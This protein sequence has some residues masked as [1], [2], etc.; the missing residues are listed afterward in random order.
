M[1]IGI[2]SAPEIFQHRM[3]ELIEGMP[4]VEV[5][6]DDFVVVGYRQT[7]EQA[8]RD[9]DKNLMKFLQQCQDCRLKFDIKNLTLKQTKVSFIGDVATSDGL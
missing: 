6:A 1:P 2:Q 9:H 4:H 5:V 8:M 7:Q 3:H